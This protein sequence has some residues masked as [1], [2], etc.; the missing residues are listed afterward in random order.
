MLEPVLI[1]TNF[2]IGV[3]NGRI[4]PSVL[5]SFNLHISVISCSELYALRGM[6][7]KEED[8]IKSFFD[9]CIILPVTLPIALQAGKLSRTRPPR[10]LPD[11]LIASTAIQLGLP[12]IT[13]D[14]A[15]RGIPGLNV[16]C[17]KT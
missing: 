4:H 14:K 2:C 5:D 3:I 7:L 9:T 12:L 6:S 16:F 8:D 17:L 15:F 10:R 13:D 11:M 1:D